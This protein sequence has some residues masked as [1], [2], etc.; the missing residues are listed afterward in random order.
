MSDDRTRRI[1][2]AGVAAAVVLV[3]AQSLADVLNLWLADLTVRPF[4]I[5]ANNS[6]F[7]VISTVAIGAAALAAAGL[8][9]RDAGH[10]IEATALSA[11]LIVAAVADA[12]QLGGNVV[13]D[14]STK[15]LYLTL[16]LGV[17]LAWWVARLGPELARRTVRVGIVCLVLSIVVDTL[18]HELNEPLRLWLRRGDPG[19]EVFTLVKQGLELGGW[20]LV[21]TGLYAVAAARWRSSE[22]SAIVSSSAAT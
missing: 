17:V 12:L 20:V 1:V 13:R 8:A 22:A 9:W 11:F 19:H 16:L 3:V 18:F 5:D 7:D 21:A 10:R 15:V 2:R 14:G 6:V 4:D